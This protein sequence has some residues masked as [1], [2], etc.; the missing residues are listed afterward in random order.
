MLQIK[1]ILMDN[2]N[3]AYYSSTIFR[4]VTWQYAIN[5][6]RQASAE[7]HCPVLCGIRRFG[8]GAMQVSLGN[9]TKA[10]GFRTEV[11]LNFGSF[12]SDYHYFRFQNYLRTIKKGRPII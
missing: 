6:V 1:V 3:N 4:N 12:R 8:N 7:T 10:H 2:I 9:V 11:T 5:R